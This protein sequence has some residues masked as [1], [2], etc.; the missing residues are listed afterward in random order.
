MKITQLLRLD[1]ER[2]EFYRGNRRRDI[3][4]C[5]FFWIGLQPRFIPIVLIRVASGL[6][7]AGVPLMPK[8]I[9]LV[10][11]ILFGLEVAVDSKIGPG[12]VMAHTQGT[13]LGAKEIG[14]NCLLYHQV[15]IGAQEMDLGFDANRRPKI[16]DNVI[17]GSGAKV[18]GNI[19]VGDRS[20][21]GA[22]AV[23]I[24]DVP[25]DC[26]AVGIPAHSTK[27]RRSIT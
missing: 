24:R 22:N 14:R 27:M 12:L 1:L 18:L 2:L 19:C 21:V 16:G 4:G 5:R 17:I 13:V 26:R 20:V 3:T 10:N 6:H 7:S 23:V 25:A 8:L 9:S 11:F 15:T